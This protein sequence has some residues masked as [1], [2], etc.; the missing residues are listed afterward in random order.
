MKIFSLKKVPRRFS[1]YARSLPLS[2]ATYIDDAGVL[3]SQASQFVPRYQGGL[4]LLE[5][6]ATNQC[7][8][9]QDLNVSPWVG[10]TRTLAAE[11]WAGNVPFFTVAKALSSSSEATSCNVVS[12]TAGSTWT[13][14]LALLA[15]TKDTCTVGLY[16]NVSEGGGGLWGNPAECTKEILSGPGVF[17]V[18]SAAEGARWNVDNLSATVPTLIRITRTLAP[19]SA[20][21]AFR[22]AVYPGRPTSTTAGD[23]VKVTR[24]QIE[25]G[26]VSTSYIPTTTAAVT[27]AADQLL[28]DYAGA[29]YETGSGGSTTGYLYTNATLSA[30]AF[31]SGS[32]YAAGARVY[33]TA[34]IYA[35]TAAP[36]V[37]SAFDP[38]AT[39]LVNGNFVRVGP[40]NR[41]AAFDGELSTSSYLSVTPAAQAGTLHFLVSIDDADTVFV[42]D[43]T[44]AT[45][46]RLRVRDG[47][48]GAVVADVTV[49]ES[50][51]GRVR[52]QYLLTDLVC[53]SGGVLEVSVTGPVAP[54]IGLI[55]W[56]T[57]EA[58]A[59]T[60]YGVRAGIRDYSRKEPDDFG[61]VQFVRRAFSKTVSAQVEVEKADINRVSDRLYGLRATP[62]VWIFS[63]DPDLSSP[64]VVY[65]F[66]RD[67]Y[68]SI[69]F[70]T[71]SIYS[72]EIEGLA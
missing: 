34:Q 15:G 7:L 5:P 36:L 55:A 65:G 9:S 39:Q 63:D 18:F 14:T 53:P 44:G 17:S 23:A 64:L 35:R 48:M 31:V 1:G 32:S 71:L 43:L 30:P 70:P 59:C 29:E 20:V 68:S 47:L 33:E 3:Q 42:G 13:M 4:M 38:F 56:G 6:A 37:G 22:C 67:F 46:L 40:D 58:M 45:R 50:A 52:S 62:L 26:S 72:L 69:D 41:L 28:A 10:C 8:Q 60:R 21:T 16:A 11:F 19:A 24:V 57:A 27:R 61:Q 66:Y 25:A 12:V 49:D 2:A 51:G 54:G